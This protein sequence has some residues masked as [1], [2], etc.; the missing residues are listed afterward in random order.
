MPSH[1]ERRL[2]P[3]SQQQMFELVADIENYPHFLPWC[4]GATIKP[5]DE[6]HLESEIVVGWLMIRERFRSRTT[7][8]P[9]HTVQVV[10]I[11][12]AFSHLINRWHFIADD[13]GCVIDFFIDFEVTGLLRVTLASLFGEATRRMITAFEQRAHQLYA[14]QHH[15]LRG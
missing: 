13:R 5:L 12:G 1:R 7:L 4:R 3:Y 6:H 11:E 15:S 2:L 14:P 10:G 9:Y 8:Q